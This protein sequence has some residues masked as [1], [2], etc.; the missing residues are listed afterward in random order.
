MR[1][2]PRFL[3][4]KRRSGMSRHWREKLDPARHADQ[5]TIH[6]GGSPVEPPRDALIEKWVYFV[7]VA[8]FT[9]QF[10]SL[11]QLRECLEFFKQRIHRTSRQPDIW[12]EHYWQR[13]FEKLPRR[14]F[15]EPKR[16]KVVAALEAAACDFGNSA[17]G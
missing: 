3:A 8:S 17:A 11:D 5:M 15:K 2:S 1:L 4:G 6:V 9:F 16:V 12:L 7:E 13:W 10:H 14:L